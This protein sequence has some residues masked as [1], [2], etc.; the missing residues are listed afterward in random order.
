ME[1][2]KTDILN[3]KKNDPHKINEKEIQIINYS[4]E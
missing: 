1:I 4:L 2:N 3:Y